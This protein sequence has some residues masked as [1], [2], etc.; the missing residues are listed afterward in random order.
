MRRLRKSG[1]SGCMPKVRVF[2]VCLICLASLTNVGWAVSK[3]FYEDGVI[4]DGDD[5]TIVQ[6][7][8]DAV[9]NMTGGLVTD[10]LGTEDTSTLNI[11]GGYAARVGATEWSFINLYD[12]METGYIEILSSSTLNMYGGLTGVVE[13]GTTNPVHLRGGAITD[14]LIARSTVDIYGYDFSYD[15]Y[16]GSYGGGRLS[17]FWT[18]GIPL[19]ID[20]YAIYNPPYGGTIDTWSHVVL[21]TIPEPSTLILLTFAVVFMRSHR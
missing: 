3:V 14:Y 6:V 20:L 18:N 8:N 7:L 16:G 19:S 1:E 10:A 2:L 9:V 21:H 13:I 12:G 15:L 11:F 17:G 5:Y 4:Q